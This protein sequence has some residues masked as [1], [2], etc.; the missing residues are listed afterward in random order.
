M[1]KLIILVHMLKQ[2]DWPLRD[3]R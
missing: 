3:S 1:T 2:C